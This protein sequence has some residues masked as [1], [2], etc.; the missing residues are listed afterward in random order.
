[1]S[2]SQFE[3]GLS[4]LLPNSKEATKGKRN[5]VSIQAVEMKTRPSFFSRWMFIEGIYFLS[6]IA[7][8]S[9]Q[10]GKGPERANLG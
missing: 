10:Y 9:M 6:E 3:L 1:M 7:V 2:S 8:I 4:F 5:L